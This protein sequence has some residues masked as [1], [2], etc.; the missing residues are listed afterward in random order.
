VDEDDVEEL[1]SGILRLTS[2]KDYVKEIVGNAWNTA[3]LNHNAREESARFQEA[4]FA[5]MQC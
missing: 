3:L 1:K 2:D 4:L 5:G